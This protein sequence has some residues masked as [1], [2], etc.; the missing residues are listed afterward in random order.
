MVTKKEE[1]EEALGRYQNS[2]LGRV[3]PSQLEAL[4]PAETDAQL[5]RVSLAEGFP[6]HW[7]ATVSENLRGS[8]LAT[9]A[10]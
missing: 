1:E 9:T 4:D 2:G 3:M 7:G 5:P 10:P 8:Q 6:D